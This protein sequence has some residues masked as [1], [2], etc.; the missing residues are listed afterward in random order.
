M[1]TQDPVMNRRRRLAFVSWAITIGASVVAFAI[2]FA[3]RDVP[4]P[5]STWGF[6]GAPEAFGLTC[7]T[8]GAIVAIRRPENINGWLFCAIGLLFAFQALITEY[9]IAAV[10]VAPGDLPFS[11][12]LG[13]LLT[14][15]WALPLGLALIFL[16]LLFPTGTFLTR[17]WRAV[18]AIGVVAMASFG[19]AVAFLPG[20]IQSATFLENPLG[21]SGIELGTYVIVIVGPAAALFLATIVLALAS[22]ALRFRRAPV[23]ARLQIKWFA[24]AALIAGPVFALHTVISV[25]LA[26]ATAP[27]AVEVVGIVALMG[28]PTAAGMAI[29]RYRLYDIDRI[30]SRTIAYGLISAIL[31][32]TYAIAILALQGSLGRILGGDTIQVA[33]STLVVAALF[34]PL[35]RRVQRVVDHRFDHARFDAEQTSSAFSERLRD[36]VDIEAVT[37][38]LDA[39]VQSALKPSTLRLWLRQEPNR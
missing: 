10:L 17:R 23:E 6:R 11:P 21:A 29:L 35:R 34:Q 24:L 1:S 36:E 7:G 16:P 13:W 2:I 22:L 18:A 9:L 15:L 30:V 33:L 8:V 25:A 28:L 37:A 32:A 12:G 3:T 31:V 19:A 26:S 5:S 20:P 38:N 14:W 27:K 4:V 39:T